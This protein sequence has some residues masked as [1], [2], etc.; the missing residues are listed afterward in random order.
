[1]ATTT[2]TLRTE[3]QTDAVE[4]RRTRDK[5]RTALQAPLSQTK[6]C[7]LYLVNGRERSSPWFYR[8][9]T[10]RKALELMQ[11]KYGVRNCILYRD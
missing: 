9:E 11:A 4:C 5:R 7:V 6:L 8:D 3:S 10:A 1:M 2:V